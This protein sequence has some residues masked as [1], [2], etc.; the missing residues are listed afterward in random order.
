MAPG[1]GILANRAS[2]IATLAT[3]ITQRLYVV[4]QSFVQLTASQVVPRYRA[5]L[6]L[7]LP[8]LEE[9]QIIRGVEQIRRSTRSDLLIRF[10]FSIASILACLALHGWADHRTRGFLRLPLRVATGCAVMGLVLSAWIV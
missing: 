4:E 9:R 8:E 6:L 2:A 10:E 3:R 7:S 5:F 1:A